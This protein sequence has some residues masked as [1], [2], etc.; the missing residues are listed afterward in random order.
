MLINNLIKLKNTLTEDKFNLVVNIFL[1]DVEFHK[2]Y[3][4]GTEE[5]LHTVLEQTCNLVSRLSNAY[6]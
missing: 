3:R 5:E 1:E 4:E 6:E 2:D